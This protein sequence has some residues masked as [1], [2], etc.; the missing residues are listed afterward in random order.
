MQSQIN[1]FGV[2]SFIVAP[3]ILTNA[4]SILTLSTSNRLGR[5]VD[6]ARQLTGKLESAETSDN[7]AAELDLRELTAV[8]QRMLI[9]IRALRNFYVALGGFASAAL[10]SLIGSVAG[11]L[12]HGSVAVTM[13]VVVIVVGVVAVGALVSGALL[14]VGETR[15]AFAVLQERAAHVEARFVKRS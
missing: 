14:L 4:S 13:L 12:A 3:A 6:R 10:L 8:Q 9:L 15:I 7:A 1:L 11:Q 5:V 2:L